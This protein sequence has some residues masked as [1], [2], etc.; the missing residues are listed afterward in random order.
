VTPTV[1]LG[2]VQ[3]P[4]D[5]GLDFDAVYKMADEL[6]YEAKH[7]GGNAIRTNAPVKAAA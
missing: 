7:A 2:L 3:L 4:A 1:S 5:G 6:L